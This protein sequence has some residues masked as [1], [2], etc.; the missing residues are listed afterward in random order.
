MSSAT[1]KR[2]E[3]TSGEPE[4]EVGDEVLGGGAGEGKEGGGLDW[5]WIGV[6]RKCFPVENGYFTVLWQDFKVGC[7]GKTGYLCVVGTGGEW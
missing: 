5:E 1:W 4:E 2:E 3:L 6:F 7:K